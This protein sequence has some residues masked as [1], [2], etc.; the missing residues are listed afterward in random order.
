MINIISRYCF[1][2]ISRIYLLF[3]DRSLYINLIIIYKSLFTFTFI[4]II[5]NGFLFTFIINNNRLR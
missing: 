5:I 2:F 3:F 1:L 4:I